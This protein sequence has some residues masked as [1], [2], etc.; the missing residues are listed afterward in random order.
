MLSWGTRSLNPSPPGAP[1]FQ[2]CIQTSTVQKNSKEYTSGFA[3]II[4]IRVF[5]WHAIWPQRY[6]K[7]ILCHSLARCAHESFKVGDAMRDYGTMI[8]RNNNFS[9]Y[10]LKLQWCQ[11][12]LQRSNTENWKRIFP[13][14]ELRSY[15]PN[16]H[17]HVSVSDLWIPT[18]DLPILLQEICGPILGIYK[19]VTDTWMW[20][21]GQRPRNS[22]KR[23]T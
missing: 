18:T 10:H 1:Q 4:G 20:K 21:L 8:E 2:G 5:T 22:K 16:F 12:T 9:E 11:A 19:L 3:S 14:K 15:S 7:L 23:N 17:T 13:E 6:R